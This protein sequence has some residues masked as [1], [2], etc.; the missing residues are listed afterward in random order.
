MMVKV[1]QARDSEVHSYGFIRDNL[2][3]LGWD[4]RNPGRNPVGQVYTQN[5]CF[6]HDE[7]KKCLVLDKP[8][9]VIKITESIF[10]VIEAK[11]THK[12]LDQAVKEAEEYAKKINKSKNIKALFISGVAGNPIDHYVIQTRFLVGNQFKP[13][14]INGKE[15][16]ALVSPQIAKT[17]LDNKSPIIDDVPIDEKLFLSKAEKINQ[18]L[19]LG[20]INKN[21]RA[22]VMAALLLA[23]I[24]DTPPNIDAKPSILI[25]EINARARHILTSQNKSD[26]FKFIEIALPP[27]EDNHLKFKAALV[28]TIQ[29]L[30]NLNIRS[31]MNSGAD[32]LGK[33]YEVFLKYG[34][35]AKE[36]GIVLTPRHIT[37]FAVEVLGITDRDVIYDPTCGTAGFLVAAFDYVRQNYSKAQVN[38]F[39]DKNLFGVEQEAEVVA[40]AIVNMIF[41]GDGK[42]NIIEGNCF[43]KNL[44]KT[45]GNGNGIVYSPTTPDEDELAVTRVLM[46]PPFALKKSD[47]KEYRFINQALKQMQDGGLLF[48][49]LPYSAMVKPGS[50]QTWRKDTLLSKNTL[51]SVVTFPPDLFYPVGVHTLGIFVKKGI[52][53]PKDQNVLWLRAIN[54]GLLK[55]KGVRL[56]HPKA[57]DD[58]ATARDMVKSFITTPTLNV[59]NVERFQKACPI[60]YSDKLLELVPENYLDQAAP[61]EQEIKQ[62][63]EQIIR[64]SVAFV[65]RAGKE[66]G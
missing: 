65:V 56:P 50:Y 42:N 62:G 5:E 26:F 17:V 41:R 22:R 58:Y 16:T 9:N 25:S 21:Y 37:K 53:H 43:Q 60:D 30:N 1:K 13:I 3:D 19:H 8:E 66:N 54:D 7:L 20:A 64:D 40:L 55:R 29:E 39:K 12:Q 49:V 11:P 51:L 59:P 44:V 57:K 47:E 48:C 36:I 45:K 52:P 10:W 46:N 27:T 63:I 33:F 23:M 6:A 35:G 34:N 32:V 18:I 38:R 28:Q 24:E 61:T 15:V 4:I 2:K 31:A 14:V